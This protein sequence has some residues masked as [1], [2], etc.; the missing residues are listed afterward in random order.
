MLASDHI[1]FIMGN[2]QIFVYEVSLVN[3]SYTYD[4]KTCEALSKLPVQWCFVFNRIE[5][6]RGKRNIIKIKYGD[7][8]KPIKSPLEL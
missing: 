3:T 8:T 1:E 4:M 2:L 6:A 5:K 7:N